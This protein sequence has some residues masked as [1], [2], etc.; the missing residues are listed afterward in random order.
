MRERERDVPFK[1]GW[2]VVWLLPCVSLKAHAQGR[3]SSSNLR[4]SVSAS[5][6][7]RA[8]ASEG[9][10]TS[11]STDAKGILNK[12]TP[13]TNPSNL[14][15]CGVPFFALP[16]A[17]LW[18]LKTPAFHP[19]ISHSK[20]DPTMHAAFLFNFA[21]LR[22]VLELSRPSFRISTFGNDR[23]RFGASPVHN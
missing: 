10:C 12:T 15:L 23:C 11:W 21:L 13:A 5:S 18:Q 4:V 7:K 1:I 17:L 6:L 16:G 19:W 20:Y 14:C 8:H 2:F 22:R 3:A 9:V